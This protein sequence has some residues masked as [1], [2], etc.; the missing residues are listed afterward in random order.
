MLGEHIRNLGNMLGTHW[1]LHGNNKN[2]P[3]KEKKPTPPGSA[4]HEWSLSF[5]IENFVSTTSPNA[6][7]F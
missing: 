3:S 2:S 7:R 4:E 1:E 5:R 6:Q